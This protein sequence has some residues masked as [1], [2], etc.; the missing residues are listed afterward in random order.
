MSFRI[1]KT[2]NNEPQYCDYI[3]NKINIAKQFNAIYDLND[4]DWR[5]QR[6]HANDDLRTEEVLKS[7]ARV[8]SPED[9]KEYIVISKDV[10]FYNKKTNAYADRYSVREGVQEVPV[11]VTNDLGQVISNQTRLKY[12]IPFSAEKVD[13]IIENGGE[14]ADIVPLQYYQGNITSNRNIRNKT[15]VGNL[16]LFKEATWQELKLAKE[17]KTVSSMTNTLD[18]IRQ[19][20]Q[21]GDNR[22]Q[23]KRSIN[24]QPE[25]K[26]SQPY[27]GAQNTP[28][29]DNQYPEQ[30]PSG[31]P[32]TIVAN[33]DEVMNYQAP[34][35][36]PSTLIST[37]T[38]KNK[39]NIE[40]NGDNIIN[41]SKQK[42][43]RS[44]KEE[45]KENPRR[46]EE[47]EESSI[48]KS[49]ISSNN[50]NNSSGSSGEGS[51][52]TSNS[53]KQQQQ[54]SSDPNPKQSNK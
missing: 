17:N 51:A 29:F 53:N 20:N 32:T 1:V 12:T 45:E 15:L 27:E 42:S 2:E 7:I 24:K 18:Q 34:S 36:I 13:E 28:S 21:G 19:K 47:K 52:T 49:K 44:E 25:Y 6:L 54:S 14:N 46:I 39:L 10:N 41:S 16:D 30:R 33:G 8:R 50:N 3:Q 26:L 4:E 37:N 48:S 22:Y 35:G 9:G 40:D 11:P 43:S 38:R 23:Q 31:I 5:I